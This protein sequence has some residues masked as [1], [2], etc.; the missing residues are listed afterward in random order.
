MASLQ[1]FFI[2][3]FNLDINGKTKAWFVIGRSDMDTSVNDCFF[4]H[5]LLSQTLG[6]SLNSSKKAC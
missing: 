3:A 5:F 2:D 1:N 4:R 6:Y